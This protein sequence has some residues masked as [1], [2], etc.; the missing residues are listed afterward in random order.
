MV[1]AKDEVWDCSASA[2][3]AETG[4]V[5]ERPRAAGGVRADDEAIAAA[6]GERPLADNADA[7]AAVGERPRGLPVAPIA[8]AGCSRDARLLEEAA[9]VPCG[10]AGDPEAEP[11]APDAAD[12]DE[13]ADTEREDATPRGD[14]VSSS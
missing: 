6:A 2:A 5:G 14:R 3:E 8:R 4:S 9:A 13:D 12:E 1:S 10:A 7:A 11:D